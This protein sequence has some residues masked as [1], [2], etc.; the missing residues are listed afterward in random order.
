VGEGEGGD[1]V[2][3]MVV[4]VVGGRDKDKWGRCFWHCVSEC[5]VGKVGEEALESSASFPL[6]LWLLLGR[7]DVIENDDEEEEETEE[8]KTEESKGKEEG[9]CLA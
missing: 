4:G 3:V 7:V 9:N 1:W 6:M 8:S 2:V 5:G